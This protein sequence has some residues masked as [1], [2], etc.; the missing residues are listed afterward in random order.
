VT[1]PRRPT[2]QYYQAKAQERYYQTQR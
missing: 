1:L 2:L